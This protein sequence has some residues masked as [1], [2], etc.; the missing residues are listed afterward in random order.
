MLLNLEELDI[1]VRHYHGHDEG[2]SQ[3]P[4]AYLRVEAAAERMSRNE[5][6]SN[7]TEKSEQYDEIPVDT[8]DQDKLV[9]DDGNELEE[10]ED[11]TGND[12][13]KM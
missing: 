1:D 6:A 9:A 7:P 10:R 12:P 11:A 2:N 3:K 13:D 4:G 8:V 5:Q